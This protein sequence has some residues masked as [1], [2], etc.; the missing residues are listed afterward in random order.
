[1]TRTAAVAAIAIALWSRPSA[2]DDR[3]SA[4]ASLEG[5]TEVRLVV[6]RIP[7]D[8]ERRTR[9]RQGDV[10]SDVA[11]GVARSGLAVSRDAPAILYANVAVA[12]DAVNCA[13]TIAL[14]VQQPVRLARRPQAGT[15][16]AATWSAGTTGIA[17]LRASV[18]RRRVREQV[19]RFVAEWRAA[20]PGR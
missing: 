18:I 1:M 14:E 11:S 9:L 8:V 3:A 15:L 13:Y 6:E 10:L 5:L 2:G 7:A 19:A 12:C 17:G 16:V 4:R 20:N